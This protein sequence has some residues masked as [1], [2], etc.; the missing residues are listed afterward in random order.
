[1]I[2]IGI[3]V[4]GV[5]LAQSIAELT[6]L[7]ESIETKIDKLSQS[8]LAAA[9][10][11]LDQAYSSRGEGNSLLRE[12]RSCFN[13]ALGLE[14]GYRRGVAYVGL[15]LCHSHLNDQDNCKK[16]LTELLAV[17]PIPS[18]FVEVTAKGVAD[19]QGKSWF[20]KMFDARLAGQ[21]STLAT[22][23]AR[24]AKYI[25]DAIR[26]VAQPSRQELIL[27]ISMDPD[28]KSLVKLQALVAAHLGSVPEWMAKN[29]IDPKELGL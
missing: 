26:R 24:R 4:S 18:F 11:N 21:L 1:L 12:A 3:I 17:I 19:M 22:I 28:A 16:A 5:G 14:S 27:G 23:A 8:E 15:A 2:D 13:K 6:G 25:P 7:M 9:L 10:R 29:K 20:Q